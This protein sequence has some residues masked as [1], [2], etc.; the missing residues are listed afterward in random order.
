LRR[1]ARRE[2]RARHRPPR[3]TDWS[4]SGQHTGLTD[5]PLNDS[6]RAKAATALRERLAGRTFVAV[7]SSPLRRALETCEA[8]GFR[9]PRRSRSGADGVG[10][11]RLRG[12]D[13][14]ADPRA[15]PGWDLWRDGCPGGEDAAAVGARADAAIAALPDAGVV[16]VFAHGHFLRTLIA[17]WLCLEPAEGVRFLL[18][19][20]AIGVLSHEHGRRVL[21][22]LA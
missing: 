18:A 2:R 21:S 6:G 8:R 16:L 14:R 5:L 17:R 13:L 19:P 4:D 12:S 20:G 22:A 3:D 11:R 9:A 15:R 1:S 7:W 10:L